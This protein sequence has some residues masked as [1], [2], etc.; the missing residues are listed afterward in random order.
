VRAVQQTSLP[1]N[2]GKYVGAGTESWPA[3]HRSPETARPTDHNSLVRRDDRP[4][5]IDGMVGG[6][7]I[8]LPTSSV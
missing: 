7:R 6:E 2:H 3:A 5:S 4:L 1:A 8:E